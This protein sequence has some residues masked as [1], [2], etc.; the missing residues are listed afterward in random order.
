MK[1]IEI[2]I[3]LDD[4]LRERIDEVAT[5]KR[6]LKISKELSEKWKSNKELSEDEYKQIYDFLLAIS[7]K[8]F[9]DSKETLIIPEDALNRFAQNIV[10]NLD[11]LRMKFAYQDF[12]AYQ[13]V[14]KLQD[15]VRRALKIREVFAKKNVSEET[16]TICK[17]AYLCFIQG[18]HVASIALCRSIVDVH[19]K[20]RLN[21]EIGELGKLNDIAYDQGIYSKGT[22]DRINQIR[23][24]GN[25]ILHEIAKG[26]S[27]S[28]YDNLKI[29]GLT[30]EV[31]QTFLS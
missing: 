6:N 26:K 19:L 22:W 20:E 11:E 10:K 24:R 21:V 27:P 17:E 29:L 3:E 25:E 4:I 28:E 31:L 15:I 16:K 8:I 5:Y 1:T 14:D 23:R 2:S 30:Q 9:L 18:Y 13:F 7:L 12:Y